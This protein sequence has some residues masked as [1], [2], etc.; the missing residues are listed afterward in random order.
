MGLLG[1]GILAFWHDV[2]PGGDAE[3]NQWHIREHIPER[4]GVSGFLRCRRYMAVS[5]GPTYFYFY[6][7]ETVETLAS[8]PYLA[9][10]NAPTPWTRRVLPLFKDNIRTACRVTQSLGRGIGGCVAT[11]RLGPLAGR[12]EELRG[13][14]TGTTL[15]A[16]IERPGIVGA[17]LCEADLPATRVPT[18]ERKLRPQE[19]AVARWVMLVD[20]TERDAVE[21]ACRDH[22]SPEALARRGA[23][24][25]ITLGVYRLVYCLAH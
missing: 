11:L 22:L 25:D 15:P 6:E 8:P 2:A 20:G 17:H 10:L 21:T 13:W 16:L 4:L 9:R 12:E 1:K 23:G 18:E 14:L 7:T 19:D 5:D 3:F 24:G